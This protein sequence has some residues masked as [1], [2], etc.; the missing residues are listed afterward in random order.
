MF[1]W[2][3]NNNIQKHWNISLHLYPITYKLNKTAREDKYE[4]KQS[5]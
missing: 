5:N 4:M 3:W 1:K 2:W